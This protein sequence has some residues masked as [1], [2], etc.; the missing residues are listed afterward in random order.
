MARIIEAFSQF[1]DGEGNPLPG[2]QLEFFE[3][4]T[5][6]KKDTF[7]DFSETVANTNPVILDGEGRCPDVFGTGSFRIFLKDKNGVQ[8]QEFDPVG[9]TDSL[10]PFTDWN[11]SINYQTDAIVRGSDGEIYVSE[12]DNNLNNDPVSDAGNNWSQVRFLGVWKSG[13]TF[14]AGDVVQTSTGNL[15]KSLIAANLN[16][17]P[18]TDDGSR[19]L[20]A[21][22]E[23]KVNTATNLLSG[24]GTLIA[25]RVNEVQ[26]SS[27]YDFPL[28]NSVKVNTILTTV[29]PLEFR[30][31]TPTLSASGADTLSFDTG[32]DT[33]FIYDLSTFGPFNWVSD[34]ISDWRLT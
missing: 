3:T 8:I 16:N 6:A 29:L 22:D 5:T 21:V 20:P 10:V 33:S 2:G 25:G 28:A 34:G 1:F 4:G 9:G 7:A 17:D 15:W 13:T 27:T 26:D 11:S 23:T 32:T 18:E 19:W 24:G 12:V 31:Q 30:D 14:D